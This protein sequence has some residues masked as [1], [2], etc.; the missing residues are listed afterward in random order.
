EAF[1]RLLVSLERVQHDPEI[2]PG[3]CRARIYFERRGDEPVGFS[4]LSALRFDRAE[5]IKRVELIGDYLQHTRVDLLRLA[6]PPLVLQRHSFLERLAEI[7]RAVRGC[8]RRRSLIAYRGEPLA[9]ADRSA[10]WDSG[11]IAR[12]PA[13]KS[14]RPRERGTHSPGFLLSRA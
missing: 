4:G 11:R 10:I 13:A 14:A 7:G 6:Q 5:E 8:H 1:E 2:D 9:R 12:P 3:V